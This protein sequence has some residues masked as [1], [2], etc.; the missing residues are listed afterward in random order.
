M[1]GIRSDWGKLLALRPSHLILGADPGHVARRVGGQVYLATPYTRRV[2]DVA[3]AYDPDLNLSLMF[4]AAWEARRLAQL[5]VTA[6]S[7]IVQAA[8]M[9]AL[10]RPR[11]GARPLD[12]LDAEFWTRWCAPVLAASE[13]VVVPD[14][15]GWADSAGV[16]HE[17]KTALGR[18]KPVYLYAEAA[19]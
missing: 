2:V 8:G 9:V 6:I 11:H 4:E 7:P 10:H 3:G 15:P 14:L 18:N 5:G 13:A 17:V 1:G 12:P 16:L 19:P